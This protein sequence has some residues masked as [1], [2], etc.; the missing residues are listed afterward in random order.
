[1]KQF[2]KLTFVLAFIS[3]IMPVQADAQCNTNSSVCVPGGTAGPFN[4]VTPGPVVST[5]LDF[6]GPS[7]AYIIIHISAPGQ[8]NMLID[9]NSSYGFL[10]VAVFNIPPGQAPCSAIQNTSNQLGCNYASASGGC[11]QFGTSFP[12]SSSVPAPTVTVGQDLM[13]VVENWSG[14]SSNFTLS[15]APGGAQAGP[16]NPAITPA[17]PFCVTGA[18]QQLIAADMGGTWSGPGVSASGMFNPAS[19]GLGT[20]TINYSI[21]TAPCAVSSSTT[22]T[23]TSATV[24]V[25]PGTTICPGGSAPL[26]ATGAGTYSWSPT[27]GLSPTTGPSVTASPPSTTT[28]TV[29]GTTGGCTSTATVTVTVG[30]APFV[31]ASPAQSYCAGVATPVTTFTGGATGTVY[32]WTNSNTGIGLGASGSGNLPSYTTTNATGA[33]IVS[34]ITVTPTI[35]SCTGT[36]QTFTIT[37]NPVPVM[38]PVTP[39][40]VCAGSSVPA[41]AFATTPTG[42]TFSWSN[43][44][45]AIGLAASGTTN[46]ASFTGTNG[47]ASP[48]SGTV[49]VTPTLNG[50]VGTPATYTITVNPLPS[51]TTPANSSVCAGAPVA[52]SAFGPSGITYSWTNSNPGIGLAASGTGDYPGFTSTNAGSTSLTGMIT[53]TPSIGTCTGTPVSYSITVNPAPVIQ[54]VANVTECVGTTIPASNFG[55]T[56]ATSVVSWSNS[57]P[58]IGLGISGS[59]NTPAFTSTNTSTGAISGTVTVTASAFGCTAQPQTYTISIGQSPTITQPSN[60]AQCSGTPVAAGNFVTNP[61]GATITWTNSNTAIGLAANGTGNSPGFTATNSGTTPVTAIMTVTPSMGTCVGAPVTF[62]ITV[63]PQPTVTADNDGPMCTGGDINLTASS[64]PGASYNWSGPG[65][66]NTNQQN[67]VLSN[68]QTSQEGTYTVT[69]TSNGCSSSA[70]TDVVVNP[71]IQAIINQA[72]PFCANNGPVTLTANVPGGTWSGNGITDA[73]TGTFDPSVAG[74]ASSIITYTA[75]NG[76]STPATMAITVNPIPAVH[77]YS[78]QLTGCAAYTSTIFDQSVPP[79]TSSSWNFGDGT[80]AST[81]GAATHTWTTPGCYTITLTSTSNGCSSTDSVSNYICVLPQAEASFTV[82]NLERPM[83]NPTF[84]FINTSVNATSYSWTFGEG[85]GSSAENPNHTYPETP[86]NYTVVLIANNAGNCLD[87]AKITVTVKDELVYYVPNAFTPDGD[88][89][90]NVF[91]PVF[92]SGFDPFNFTMLIYNRWGEILFESHNVNEGWDG[93][94]AGEPVKEGVYTWTVQFR[95]SRTDKKITDTGFVTMFK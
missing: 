66:Y 69:I 11:N 92:Y 64:Y 14:S 59:G 61:P 39:V 77:I 74:A 27:T 16:P 46:Y 58:A 26:T 65:S 34:T 18:S 94:Y 6:W 19:A 36:P 78:D 85:S 49:T 56:P 7:M 23:V 71:G 9:G 44:N 4:F 62:A 89:Y 73:N 54:P 1:M 17:G 47:T 5:C 28:Y 24:S 90:N 12:C 81:T 80:T 38:T 82:D 37:V 53:V 48:I 60:V 45:T 67:P 76:C 87:S 63:N 8:L 93:T 91:K 50:C 42:S 55:V 33:P 35:G 15:L 41:S 30:G 75:P 22:V 20:H 52:G 72:G 95:D 79:S 51:M 3:L 84:Q 25:S 2:I 29:T 32:N 83:S 68:I 10:D 57:N 13:I 31:A 40:T 70:T 43:S 88:E 86:G 21:G